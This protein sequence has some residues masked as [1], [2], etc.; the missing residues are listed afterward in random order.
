MIDPK[1]SVSIKTDT[2]SR[3]YRLRITS[4]LFKPK[5]SGEYPAW[6]STTKENYPITKPYQEVCDVCLDSKKLILNTLQQLEGIES[7]AVFVVFVCL[8]SLAFLFIYQHSWS[9]VMQFF[10]C[11]FNFKELANCRKFDFWA[12]CDF[13]TIPSSKKARNVLSFFIYSVTEIVHMT[14]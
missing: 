11:F 14:L 13:C 2:L 3:S 7:D 8:G 4:W 6:S 10:C 12:S 9:P 1:R 5:Y